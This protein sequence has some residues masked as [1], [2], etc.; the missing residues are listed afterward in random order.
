MP[1]FRNMEVFQHML[2]LVSSEPQIDMLV[3]SLSLDWL[4]GVDKGKQIERIT[5]FLAGPARD[6]MNESPMW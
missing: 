3:L 6:F 1:I 4:Y 5:D 2:H